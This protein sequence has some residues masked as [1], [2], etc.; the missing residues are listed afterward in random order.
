MAQIYPNRD[1]DDIVMAALGGI[2]LHGGGVLELI[3]TLWK[4]D[5]RPA[6]LADAFP[7]SASRRTV[8]L[9]QIYDSMRMQI[10]LPTATIGPGEISVEPPTTA[11][12]PRL[13]VRHAT[14]GVFE[15]ADLDAYN[16]LALLV[17][18]EADLGRTWINRAGQRVSAHDLLDSAW[19]HYL[20][21]RTPEEEFADHSYLHLVG[22]L[23]AYNHRL[24]AAERRD[25]NSLKHRLLSVELERREFGGYAASEALGH[26]VESIGFLLAEADVAWSRAERAKVLRWLRKLETEWFREIDGVPVQHL[27][28]LL[29]GMRFVES[30]AARLR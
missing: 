11:V 17:R 9:Q 1:S 28:H 27:S 29:H 12:L 7:F 23:L 24:G 13:R 5:G 22:I 30:N 2:E 14:R 21:P 8:P 18:H 10:Y 20:L 19:D 26:Y 25:P 16:A 6:T 3:M 4:P 15:E